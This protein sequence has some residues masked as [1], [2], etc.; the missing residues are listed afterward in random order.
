MWLRARWTL[1][2]KCEGM[3]IPLVIQ[4]LLQRRQT[5]CMLRGHSLRLLPGGREIHSGLLFGRLVRR[6]LRVQLRL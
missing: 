4:L 5:G 6:T 3:C 1:T 2:L